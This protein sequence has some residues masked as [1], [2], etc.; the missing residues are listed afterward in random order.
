[1]KYI[2]LNILIFITTC[3]VYNSKSQ[4]AAIHILGGLS[5]SPNASVNRIDASGVFVNDLDREDESKR[6]SSGAQIGIDFSL[7]ISENLRLKSGFNIRNK[8]FKR[9]V[10]NDSTDLNLTIHFLDFGIPILLET[11]NN[12]SFFNFGFQPHYTMS[13]RQFIKGTFFNNRQEKYN[14]DAGEYKINL[15]NIDAVM[16][17]IIP[18]ERVS[19]IGRGTLNLLDMDGQISSKPSFKGKI[20]NF[21]V[22]VQMPLCNCK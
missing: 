16:E 10:V 11:R 19:I 14:Y 5:H 8:S 1:M 9:S 7:P 12:F 3:F 20:F 21:L 22:G 13:S 4:N 17:L 15:L 18:L 2:S 6:L